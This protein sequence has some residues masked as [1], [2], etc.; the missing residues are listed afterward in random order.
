[1]AAPLLAKEL[2]CSDMLL[3]DGL[4][5]AGKQLV[6]KLVSNFNRVECF[7]YSASLEQFFILSFLGHLERKP[8]V[9]YLR[10]IADEMVYNRMIGRNLNTRPGDASSILKA[11]DYDDYIRRSVDQEG[12]AAVA[13]FNAARR[14]PCFMTHHVLAHF[15]LFVDAYP[16]VKLVHA[17]RNP[18]DL[19]HS[20]HHRD[21]GI[22][23]G[24]D[25]RAFALAIELDGQPAPWW[26]EET[27]HLYPTL[28]P[29]DRVV[30][31]VLR[32]QELCDD[33]HADLPPARQKQ[34]HYI[35][36]EHLFIDAGSEMDRI[37]R[38]FDTEPCKDFDLVLA[39]E[40]VPRPAAVSLESRQ[41]KFE[42]LR[43]IAS[44]EAIA[45]ISEASRNYEK[46]WD[47]PPVE[48]V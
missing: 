26:G 15:D 23:I 31:D 30:I 29:V 41:K 19:I 1:M 16:A 24:N 40:R 32:L 47:L 37:A 9:A 45:R 36:Y 13:S 43:A 27:A 34:V 17:V 6:S 20:W 42:E 28:S 35:S 18:V 5:R 44:E 48:A 39:R 22:R 8:A 3:V 38:F 10:L 46:Q 2:L 11:N 25:P 12:D 33:A 7:Q 21:W 14:L 4:G